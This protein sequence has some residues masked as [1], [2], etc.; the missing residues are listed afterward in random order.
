M[1][2]ISLLSGNLNVAISS[3]PT[4][5]RITASGTYTPS[6]GLTYAIIELVSGGGA[7][8]G[9]PATA[10]SQQSSGAAGAG[11][12]YVKFLA[13]AA[14]IGVS[15][16]VTIG[17]GGTG[18]SGGTGGAGGNTSFGA[19]ASALGS[20]GG[21]AG[22]ATN[23]SSGSNQGA[24]GGTSVVTGTLIQSANG[25]AGS[26]SFSENNGFFAHGN[27]GD[28]PYG[29]GGLGSTGLVALASNVGTGNGAGASGNCNGN[30]AAARTGGAGT[31]GICVIEEHF[32]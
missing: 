19:L 16:A 29:A 22:T 30:S 5:V 27:G 17:A 18:V 2:D 9:S 3:Q 10:A 26:A 32:D 8:G 23:Q 25:N 14:Q 1:A 12:S 15:Q 21:S 7:A 28:S 20:S 11:G 24:G 13:T 31:A 6:A 4:I